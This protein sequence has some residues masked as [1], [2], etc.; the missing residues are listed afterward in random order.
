MDAFFHADGFHKDR[1]LRAQAEAIADFTRFLRF[2]SDN[3]TEDLRMLLE[4]LV[5]QHVSI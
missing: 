4:K 3:Q 2:Q 5:W 1:T